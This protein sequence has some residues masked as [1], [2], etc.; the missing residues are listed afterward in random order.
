MGE[1]RPGIIMLPESKPK[2][3]RRKDSSFLL[4]F[5]AGGSLLAT[6]FRKEAFLETLPLCSVGYSS[7]L[8]WDVC[9]RAKYK[10]KR[11]HRDALIITTWGFLVNGSDCKPLSASMRL[12]GRVKADGGGISAVPLGD[13]E[14]QGKF[15]GKNRA[16]T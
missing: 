5:S 1:S 6:G 13:G 7:C 3:Q 16:W 4:N 8:S 9:F 10:V 14:M 11:S 15:K 12:T 2:M